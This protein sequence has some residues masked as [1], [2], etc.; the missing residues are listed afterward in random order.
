MARQKRLNLP[1]A[2]YHV[3]ARGLNG[4]ALFKDR[5]D[6]EE[7]LRWLKRALDNTACRCHAWALMTNH[8]HL[9]VQTSETSLSE[10][11]RKTLTG[12]AKYFNRRYKRRGYVYQN[13][14]KSILCQE[15]AYLLEL[16]RYIHLN[17]VRAGIVGTLGELD[18]YP[19][20]GHSAFLGKSA[21]KFQCTGD[22]L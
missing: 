12:Y 8:V 20:T 18:R 11:A 14:Y 21:W 15:D 19:W 22:I 1:G 16:V 17:P 13:R 9:L 5:E 3:I 6:R 7:F 10:F 2:I 4:A